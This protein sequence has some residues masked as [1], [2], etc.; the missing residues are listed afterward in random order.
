[1]YK[2]VGKEDL[3]ILLES[4]FVGKPN[5]EY[6]VDLMFKNGNFVHR[7]SVRA[8]VA[9]VESLYADVKTIIRQA[10]ERDN[11]FC[12]AIPYQTLNQ[13]ITVDELFH[14]HCTVV[15]SNFTEV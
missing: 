12:L 13:I 6:S 1:M 10:V 2:K 15:R 7:R 4:Y 5:V 8:C 3:K 9:R 11:D 14:A